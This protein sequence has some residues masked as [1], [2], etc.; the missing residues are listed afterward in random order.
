[1]DVSN[2]LKLYS[3]KLDE[4]LHGLRAN[5]HTNEPTIVELEHLVYMI[6]KMSDKKQDFSEGKTNRWLG[7]IQGVLWHH[8][9]FTIDQMREHN[10]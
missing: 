8:H 2:T 7:F 9:I 1:M 10:R 4:V 6:E 5:P 3:T